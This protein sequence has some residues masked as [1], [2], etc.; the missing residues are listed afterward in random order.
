M[1]SSTIIKVVIGVEG[2]W[3]TILTLAVV[4]PIAY[5]TP[6]LDNGS[7][8]DPYD[9]MYMIQNSPSLFVSIP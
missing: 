5:L 3:G 1:D 6:G 8:E 2:L 9:A 4:Y 7:F